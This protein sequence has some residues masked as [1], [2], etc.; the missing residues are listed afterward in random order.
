[1]YLAKDFIETAEGL[2]FA[3][4]E[5]GLEQ[6]L[7]LGFLRYINVN[8]SLQKVN[9]VAA[10]K[11]L[12]NN[13]PQYCYCSKSKQ[14]HLHA[15]PVNAIFK[16]YQPRKRLQKILASKTTNQVENDLISLCKLFIN[17]G[18]NMNLAGITGSIL[19]RAQKP[20]SDIDLVFYSYSVFQKA[21]QIIQQLIATTDC[22]QLTEHNWQDSYKR[23]Q[24]NLSYSE[25]KWH[26]KRK[27]NK[28]LINQRKFDL[29]FV[30]KV[31]TNKTTIKYKKLNPIVLKAQV[32]DD[33]LAYSYPAEFLLN[34]P[35][36]KSI[37]SYTATYIGQ[38]KAGEWVEVSGILEQSSNNIKRIIV[39]VSREAH[40]HYIKLIK[41]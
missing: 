14:V 2:I 15:V 20:D 41:S 31:L 12:F 23:R 24:C 8:N 30:P 32:I 29:S 34:D 11:F 18:L 40:G 9:T 19:I 1:M 22:L 26:E 33:T 27:F 25:Y 3:V 39:G 10:N 4:I 17:L 13:Y 7:V 35:H 5:N 37:V 6:G 16:H 21:R 28:A 38:A 36:I